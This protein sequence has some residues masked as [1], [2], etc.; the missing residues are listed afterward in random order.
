M[1]NY[2]G[3]AGA[4]MIQPTKNAL[5]RWLSQARSEA[6]AEC[7]RRK[8]AERRLEIATRLIGEA[9]LDA[10]LREDKEA[11]LPSRNLLPTRSA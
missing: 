5:R 7:T 1:P 8:A 11:M 2:N 6:E 3:R 10:A 4:Y 9:V